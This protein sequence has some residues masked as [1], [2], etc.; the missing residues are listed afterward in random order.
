[1]QPFFAADGKWYVSMGYDVHGHPVLIEVDAPTQEFAA[2][3]SP[4]APPA[5]DSPLAVLLGTRTAIPSKAKLNE[6]KQG[7]F[8]REPEH[9]H[10]YQSIWFWFFVGVT[11]ILARWWISVMWP[12]AR[13]MSYGMVDEPTA[14][15]YF[16][17]LCGWLFWGWIPLG[18]G[19]IGALQKAGFKRFAVAWS[20]ALTALMALFFA[21]NQR[22]VKTW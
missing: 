18:I 17:A 20:V 10:W 14:M 3:P 5:P 8:Y 16:V 13:E 7:L 1:M 12:E 2:I 22:T 21:R 6:A 15:E 11:A 4:Q 19:A 9:G